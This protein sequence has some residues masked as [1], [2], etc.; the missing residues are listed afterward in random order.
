[1]GATLNQ[2]PLT[3]KKRISDPSQNNLS[4]ASL[5]ELGDEDSILLGADL[6]NSTDCEIGWGAVVAQRTGRKPR[7]SLFKVPHHGSRTAHRDDI[8]TEL[9]VEKPYSITTPWQRG[10]NRLPNEEDKQRISSLSGE[11]YITAQNPISIKLRYPYEVRKQVKNSSIN[12]LSTAYSCGHVRV[13]F[14]PDSFSSKTISLFNGAKKFEAN[15]VA[16]DKKF[17]NLGCV[18]NGLPVCTDVL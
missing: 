4:I 15:R 9:L 2:L 6:E 11:A 1:M 18:V 3:A 10:G 13:R 14:T 12:L 17:S 5:L 8:W 16:K 7:S